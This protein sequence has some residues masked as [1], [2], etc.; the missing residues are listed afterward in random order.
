M[1][2]SFPTKI[3]KIK[4]TLSQNIAKMSFIHFS[5]VEKSKSWSLKKRDHSHDCFNGRVS[6]VNRALDGSTYPG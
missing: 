4:S 3:I 1:I 5:F 6:T 2:N